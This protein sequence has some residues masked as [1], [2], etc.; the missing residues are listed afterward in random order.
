MSIQVGQD[1]SDFK[2]T[3]FDSENALDSL[4][5]GLPVANYMYAMTVRLD[6]GKA[7]DVDRKVTFRF[8]DADQDYTLHVRRGVAELSPR[9]ADD[10]DITVTTDSMV[11]KRILAAIEELLS[12]ER[13]EDATVN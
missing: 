6:A 9:A 3:T 7:L 12:G 5:G 2:L 11:W 10:A 13:P 8:P 4:L 1:V